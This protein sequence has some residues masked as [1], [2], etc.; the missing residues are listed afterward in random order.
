[1]RNK[2]I[3]SLNL[4][5]LVLAGIFSLGAQ[6][7]TTDEGS[8]PSEQPSAPMEM[9][10][11]QPPRDQGPAAPPPSQPGDKPSAG[12]PMPPQS[13]ADQ[14]PIN[15]PQAPP[16]MAQPQPGQPQAGAEPQPAGPS[17]EGPAE[18]KQGVGR[19]SLIH[20]AVSTQRGDSGEWSAAVLN[21]PVVMGDKISTGD[22]GRAEVQL[23]YAN[24]LR[25]GP[26]SQATIANFTKKFIQVQ[27][28]QGIVNYSVFG[29]SE[30]EP[31]IDTPNVALHP[32][33]QDGVF[34]IE[35]RSDGDSI[36]I[37]RKGEAQISTPQ[38]IADIKA[39]DMA[40]VR[41]SGADAR[42]KIAGAPAHD[43]W[44]NWNIER[45]RMIHNAN[46]W[47]HT[48]KYYVGSEDLDTY[49][50]W[51]NVPDYGQVWQPDEPEGWAPY[52]DGN[53]VWEPYYGWTWVGY[54]PWGWAP[55]HYGRWLWYGGAWGWWPGP[56]WGQG[57]YR[58]FWAPAYVSFFGFGGGFGLGFGFGWGGW[59]GFGWLPIGPCDRFFP[60]WGGYA[61]RFGTV[62]FNR[63]GTLNRFG[64][65]SPLHGGTRFSNVAHI[66]DAHIGGALSI[67]NANRF[68]AGHT[69]AVAANRSQLS[70]ARMM[71]G[72]MPVMPSRA[73]LSASGRAAAAST[74]HSGASQHFF[75]TQSAAHPASFQ[76]QT[77]HLQSAMQASHVSSVMAGGR[78]GASESR[79]IST[80]SSARSG[81]AS[82][83][84][85]A[86][87]AS[88]SSAAAASSSH[89]SSGASSARSESVPSARSETNSGGWRSFSPG[90]AASASGRTSGESTGRGEGGSYWNRTSPSSGYSR[91]SGSSGYERGSMG[92]RPQL[93]MRQPIVQ[94]RSSEGYGREGY[95][96]SSGG[97]RGSPSY[98]GSHGSY[99][100]GGS[101]SAPS[102]G[103]HSGGGGGGGGHS[104]GGH[105]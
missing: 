39:G 76:Q 79:S 17:G 91:E 104:G 3:G 4:L 73:S 89:V 87:T 5:M 97:Y 99:G 68:G 88:R 18:V 44:D 36:V 25:L 102:S 40:T 13:Q 63:L 46:A 59:G 83:T 58:P 92:S 35:L 47:N 74:I 30:A 64:G 27:V 6:A 93:N 33:H 26:N 60:W 52:R 65:I 2:F 53:W 43:D 49:G 105:R 85:E 29:E 20:G 14:P 38:G 11:P 10:Q 28:G 7:Q 62:G 86:S 98:G 37:L 34:R 56:V 72:N 51:Q 1:M 100:G 45:D 41:G 95:G 22:G 71:T 69:T 77:A 96:E 31:E 42:Y 84:R 32:A 12:Q 48:N 67:V 15:Q 94:P 61:G 23:D 66:N 78:M 50:H 9:G 57:F 101:H 90:G 16:P 70:G 103:G 80:A 19:I 54:E 55:Y 82:S 8:G 21:Q 24:I 81:A 75:G